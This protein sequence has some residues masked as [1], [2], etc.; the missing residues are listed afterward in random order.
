MMFDLCFPPSQPVVSP[1]RLS[2]RCQPPNY[3][4]KHAHTQARSQTHNHWRAVEFRLRVPNKT[5][6]LLP[7]KPHAVNAPRRYPSSELYF[8]LFFLSLLFRPAISLLVSLFT[9]SLVS[10]GGNKERG[11]KGGKEG[12]GREGGNG[13]GLFF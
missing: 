11:K 13:D 5:K 7:S 2:R 1:S 8:F 12:E 9:S 3:P 4:Q 10:K 6:L